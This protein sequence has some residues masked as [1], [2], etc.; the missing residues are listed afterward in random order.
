M[1]ASDRAWKIYSVKS[2]LGT[3]WPSKW[4]FKKGGKML[5]RSDGFLPAERKLKRQLSQDVFQAEKQQVKAHNQLSDAL[6]KRNE[7]QGTLTEKL[8]DAG[9]KSSIQRVGVGMAERGLQMPAVAKAVDQ[10]LQPLGLSSELGKGF[11]DGFAAQKGLK[12]G[13]NPSQYSNPNPI[14]Y[15]KT[16]T[17]VLSATPQVAKLT[18]RQAKVA[19]KAERYTQKTE[20]L[21]EVKLANL[22]QKQGELRSYSRGHLKSGSVQAESPEALAQMLNGTNPSSLIGKKA[23]QVLDVTGAR[24]TPEPA[25]GKLTKP[26]KEPLFGGELSPKEKAHKQLEARDQRLRQLDAELRQQDP[27]ALNQ[28]IRERDFYQTSTVG[29]VLRGAA[30]QPKEAGIVLSHVAH[31][32]I[33]KGPG[34]QALYSPKTVKNAEYQLSHSVGQELG[35]GNAEKMLQAQVKVETLHNQGKST[36]QELRDLHRQKALESDR[37]MM[38]DA[39]GDTFFDAFESARNLRKAEKRYDATALQQLPRP[40]DA[41]YLDDTVSQFIPKSLGEGLRRPLRAWLDPPAQP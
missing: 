15:T 8:V 3:L 6:Q 27:S 33:P 34:A 24:L 16:G 13:L 28:A 21:K 11:L 26:T 40:E 31:Q 32:H 10:Q 2:K 19:R 29:D 7:A 25:P 4:P 14:D 41:L 37:Q 5:K 35:K 30:N 12:K 36:A 18:Q 23:V 20:Q 22:A 1:H 9:S 38:I 17:E 39:D